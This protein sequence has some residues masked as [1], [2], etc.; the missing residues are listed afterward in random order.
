MAAVGDFCLMDPIFPGSPGDSLLFK[1]DDLPGSREKASSCPL[2]GR[3]NLSLQSPRKTST[4]LPTPRRTHQAPPAERRNHA[5][6][7]AGTLG[8][9][10]PRLLTP[11]AARSHLA[12]E[13]APLSQGTAREL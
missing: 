5:R 6:P 9:H 8:L 11:Q 13:D 12:R 2:I 7:A 4:S 1:E 3:R 10:H